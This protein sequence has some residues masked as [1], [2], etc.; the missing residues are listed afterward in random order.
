MTKKQLDRLV[1]QF[2]KANR[3]RPKSVS[4]FARHYGLH[5]ST[6]NKWIAG[7][8]NL[9]DVTNSFLDQLYLTAKF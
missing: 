5:P 7:E 1:T 9:G 6:L 3:I 2:C 4:A 8:R